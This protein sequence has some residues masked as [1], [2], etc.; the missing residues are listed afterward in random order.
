MEH[1]TL[2][3]AAEYT[4]TVVVGRVHNMVAVSLVKL[5][6]VAEEEPLKSCTNDIAM[7]EQSLWGAE[8]EQFSC[9]SSDSQNNGPK[10]ENVKEN[11]EN[12]CR[13]TKEI[14]GAENC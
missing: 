8:N 12:G 13:R 5:V 6:R 1:Y 11:H 3:C 10:P 14:R 9:M 7:R 2:I 4:V